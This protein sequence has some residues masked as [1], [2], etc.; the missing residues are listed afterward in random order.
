MKALPEYIFSVS[1]F[2]SFLTTDLTTTLRRL[3]PS[4]SA[5]SSSFRLRARFWLS[6]TPSKSPDDTVVNVTGFVLADT[7][8]KS[9]I[10]TGRYGSIDNFRRKIFARRRER[11]FQLQLVSFR[12]NRGKQICCWLS[13]DKLT[14][15]GASDEYIEQ[16]LS[17]V[18]NLR[19]VPRPW[20]EP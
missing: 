2:S 14:K 4:L 11:V 17:P 7:F 19:T 1:L 6:P 18:L 12:C 20:H 16:F 3:S 10:M 8:S 13:Q 15:G 9:I 5:S